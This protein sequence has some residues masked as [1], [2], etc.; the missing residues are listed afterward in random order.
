[1]GVLELCFRINYSYMTLKRRLAQA[2][3][4]HVAYMT[5][6]FKHTAQR[7]RDFSICDVTYW[8]CNVVFYM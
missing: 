8:L 4:S 2:S 6:E 7:L 3:E 1:M 5:H